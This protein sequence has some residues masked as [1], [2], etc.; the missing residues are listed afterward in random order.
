MGPDIRTLARAREL[1][2]PIMMTAHDTYTT[3]HLVDGI[4]GTV[5]AENKEK[6]AIVERIVGGAIN[7]GCIE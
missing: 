6:I 1:D 7:L 4:V 2:V 3:G 5:N